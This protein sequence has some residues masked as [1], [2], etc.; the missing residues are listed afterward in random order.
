MKRITDASVLFDTKRSDTVPCSPFGR[1]AIFSV[2]L[3]S[4]NITKTDEKSIIIIT[5]V[6]TWP[7]KSTERIRRKATAAVVLSAKRVFRG[8]ASIRLVGICTLFRCLLHGGLAASHGLGP[9]RVS[10]PLRVTR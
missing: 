10:C 1:T 6:S 9:V 5:D 3:E 8:I 7:S 2:Y 4:K